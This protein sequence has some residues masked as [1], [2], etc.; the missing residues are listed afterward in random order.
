MVQRPDYRT[1]LRFAFLIVGWGDVAFSCP[2]HFRQYHAY[3]E[4]PFRLFTYHILRRNSR[5][6][7]GHYRD[8]GSFSGRVVSLP[9]YCMGTE[10]ESHL[11]RR[12]GIAASL[13]MLCQHSR[14]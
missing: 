9:C 5:G 3:D 12:T 6:V 14:G 10:S 8:P 11:A 13:C 4:F 2:I 7:S 1:T